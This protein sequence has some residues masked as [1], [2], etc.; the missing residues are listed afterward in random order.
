MKVGF[1]H[2]RGWKCRR[3][4]LLVRSPVRDLRYRPVVHTGN[5][6]SSPEEAEVVRAL[7]G[8]I[9]ASNP[10]WINRDGIEQPLTLSDILIIAPYNAQVF[11][12]QKRYCRD[13]TDRHG[14]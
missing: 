1:V 6:S 5:Q 13:A 3:S 12:L 4:D 2:D 10:S 7:V 9:L 14:R 11:E 8:D